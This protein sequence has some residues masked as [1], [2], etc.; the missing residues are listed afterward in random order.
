ERKKRCLRRGQPERYPLLGTDANRKGSEFTCDRHEAPER[1]RAEP[2]GT[3]RR[4]AACTPPCRRFGLH[5]NDDGSAESCRRDSVDGKPR[6]QTKRPGRTGAKFACRV[7]AC[8]GQP[9]DAT[10][11]TRTCVAL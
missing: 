6:P 3:T 1:L 9:Q 4:L 8:A 10:D 11:K 2:H 7:T 5:R